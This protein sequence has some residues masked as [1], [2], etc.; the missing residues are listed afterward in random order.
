MHDN[1]KQLIEKLLPDATEREAFF[2]CY[3]EFLPK[4]IK[5]IEHAISVEAFTEYTK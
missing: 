4:S 2:S 3:R 5:I 1:Y